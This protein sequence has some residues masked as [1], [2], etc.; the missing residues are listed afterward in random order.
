MNAPR[1]R[2]PLPLAP[3]PPPAYCGPSAAEVQAQ[4]SEFVNPGVFH[5]YQNPLM[6]VAGRM[7]Y[8]WDDRGRQYLDALGGIVTVSV[9][10]CHPKVNHAI[11][12]QLES[13]VHSTTIYLHP[14]MPALAQRIA[15]KMPAGSGLASTYFTNSGTEANE[16]AILLARMHT[17][18]HDVISLRNAYHG[19]SQAAL[20]LTAVG[21]WKFPVAAPAGHVH[22]PAPYCYRCPLGLTYPSCDVKCARGVEE[23]I[24]Y[25]TSGEIAAFIAEPIQGVGGVVTPPPEYFEIVYGI[26]RKFGGLCIADEVQ[27]AWGRTGAHYWGFENWN[28]TPDVVTAAKGLGNG[29]AV[30]ACITRREVAAHTAKRVH[31]N[32]FAGNP[33]P[34]A[35]GLETLAVIDAEGLQAAAAARGMQLLD[36]LR[37]LQQRHP[38]IGEVRGLGLLLGIELVQDRGTRAPAGAEA[39]AVLEAARERGLLLGRGG[40]YGNVIRLAP[41][42][43]L[44]A[45]DSEF[46]LDCLDDCLTRT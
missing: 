46:L 23:A 10:H 27:T 44:T 39:A 45:A 4:R 13:L 3:S 16:L 28:V 14:A 12:A 5:Y 34:M 31:F 6:L 36:G 33:L 1:A 20:G 11:A 2:V 30:A 21:T 37:E 29:T 15:E 38:R 18:R 9:G 40:L 43:C 17:G 25:Q 7:Q 24:R 41:P 19:G 42:M 32:T 8:V 35:A 22:V 26:V